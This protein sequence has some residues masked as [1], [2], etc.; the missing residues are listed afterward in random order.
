MDDPLL[1]GR[2]ERPRRLL[3]QLDDLRFRQSS[4]DRPLLQG[5]SGYEFHRQKVEV[6]FGVKIVDRGDIGV[7]ELGEGHGFPAEALSRLLIGKSPGRQDFQGDVPFQAFV[8]GPI[9]NAHAA[10]PDFF[11]NAI[12]SERPTYHES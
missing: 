9:D 5:D 2:F 12:M 6:L 11:D 7:V 1:V 4:R 3:S 8:S 10:G